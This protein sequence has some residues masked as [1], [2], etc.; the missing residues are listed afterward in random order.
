M[1]RAV[2][3]R[4]VSTSATRSTAPHHPS[5]AD[6][7]PPRRPEGVKMLEGKPTPAGSDHATAAYSY[8]GDLARF[9]RD[10]WRYVPVPHDGVDPLPD[11]AA[12]EGFFAACYQAS[13]LREEE[14]PVIFRAILAEPAQF[15]PEGRPPEGLQRLT[16][17]RSLPFDPRELRRLSAAADPQ[18][19]LIGVRQDGE[20][21]LWIWGLINSGTRW[22]RD[23]QGGRRAGAPLPP[24]PVVHANA[25]GSI[26]VYKGHELVGK[27][28]GGRLSGSR[29]DPFESE[30]LPG[31]FS[32]F[33]EE[34]VQRHK[35][36]RNHARERSGERWAPLDPT[37]P[38]RIAERMMKRVISVLR[39]A[40]HGGTVIFVPPKNSGEP[41]GEHPYID[42][43]YRFADGPARLCF[44]DL[45]VDILNRLA[46]LYGTAD[47]RE[48]GVVGWE[49]FEVTTDAQIETLDEAVFD[50]AHLIASLAA[51]DGAVVMS[52]RN[53][54]LGFGG[55]VSGKLP[56]LKSVWRA[57]DLEG[58]NVVEEETG[59]VGARHRS[60]YRLANA[61]PGSV[62]VVISQDGGVRWVCQ[63]GGRVTYWEQE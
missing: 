27:L 42:L 11:A 47:Q 58:E 53:E 15:D 60:A 49:E 1:T 44:P 50:V 41:S 35:A 23:V 34:L 43:R 4:G 57:L 6:E 40:R 28:Q 30:W 63:K 5:T 32:G 3:S 33:L 25:P 7:A 14:R 8:P 18:R 29:A 21:T 56:D 51:A 46:Q 10:R 26:E 61:L 54:L 39:D 9:V 37:L 48:P 59:D 13:M 22:L 16:F 31:Q 45:V 38:L 24:V 55:M 19:T 20:G 12:L 2:P 52:K 36:A 62:A 17:P